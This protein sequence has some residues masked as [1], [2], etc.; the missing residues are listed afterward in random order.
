MVTEQKK[1]ADRYS[2]HSL[3]APNIRRS[4]FATIIVFLHL[5]LAGCM[6][7]STAGPVSNSIAAELQRGVTTIDLAQHTKFQ[8]SDAVIFAPYAV[9]S[10]I[11][12]ELTLNDKDCLRLSPDMVPEGQFLLVFR[13]NEQVIHHEFHDRSNGDFKIHAMTSTI[14]RNRGLFTV[15]IQKSGN[16][17][18]TF[19]HPKLDATT[20][21][22]PK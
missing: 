15:E 10:E 13:L 22:K 18:W 11:C 1:R 20:M 4:K 9:R 2:F 19:L 17:K 14:Q 21:D 12:K 3:L 7:I 6:F 8:W 5:C 16:S